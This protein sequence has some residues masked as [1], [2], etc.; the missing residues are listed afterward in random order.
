MS[1]RAAAIKGLAGLCVLAFCSLAGAQNT[2]SGNATAAV[3][4]PAP[5]SGDINYQCSKCL[6]QKIRASK[7]PRTTQMS[8]HVLLSSPLKPPLSRRGSVF[9]HSPNAMENPNVGDGSLMG[10]TCDDPKTAV[11][12]W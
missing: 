12:G 7:L 5:G 4:S 11:P 3:G 10:S 2:T 8:A 1:W 9:I 6:T